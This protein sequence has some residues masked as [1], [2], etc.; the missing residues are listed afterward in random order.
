MNATI[1]MNEIPA[2]ALKNRLSEGSKGLRL[3]DVR[4]PA[5]YDE[6]HIE[7]AELHPLDRFDAEKV[8]SGDPE[9]SQT[10]LVCK[11]GKRATEACKKLH[12]AG[13]TGA[14]ILT[15]GVEAWDTE[16][17]AVKRSGRKVISLERQVRIAA[18]ALALTGAILGF[19][20]IPLWHILPGFIGTGLLFAGLTDTC[21]MGM[22]LAKMPWNQRRNLEK[23]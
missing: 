21:G 14:T 20:V 3:I 15:G 5:E 9:G 1:S 2:K 22:M 23:A 17:Y 19:A 16:G 18:G 6:C 10:I 4:T 13:C 7:G 11:S 12:A 8:K